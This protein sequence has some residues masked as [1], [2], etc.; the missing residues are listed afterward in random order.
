MGN[1]TRDYDGYCRKCGKRV[2]YIRCTKCDGKV[3]GTWSSCKR[4]KNTGYVCSNKPYDDFHS[5]Q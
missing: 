1:Y 5:H 4:C 3:S 2:R